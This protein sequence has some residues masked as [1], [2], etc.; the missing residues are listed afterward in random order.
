MHYA[1][2]FKLVSWSRQNHIFQW[3]RSQFKLW[4]CQGLRDTL[5]IDSRIDWESYQKRRQS[6]HE[7]RN[8]SLFVSDLPLAWKASAEVENYGNMRLIRKRQR[9]SH[10]KMLESGIARYNSLLFFN[11]SLNHFSPPTVF[12]ANATLNNA[13]KDEKWSRENPSSVFL[14]QWEKYEQA[15]KT[16]HTDIRRSHPR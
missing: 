12:N 10:T 11:S 3:T 16:E 1:T 8:F 4:I 5:Q 15:L 7:T 14:K 6:W 13:Q 2:C 9:T